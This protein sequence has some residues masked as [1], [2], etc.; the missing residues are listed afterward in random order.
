MHIFNIGLRQRG[1][2]FLQC[3]MISITRVH[4]MD[5]ISVAG[6]VAHPSDS[7]D[8]E[9][10]TGLDLAECTKRFTAQ[11]R[12][13]V[14]PIVSRC[15]AANAFTKTKVL[16]MMRAVL[17]GLETQAIY[18]T[19]SKSASA[20]GRGVVECLASTPSDDL[21]VSSSRTSVAPAVTRVRAGSVRLLQQRSTLTPL[22]ETLPVAPEIKSLP[23]VPD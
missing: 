17:S 2:G 8:L 10:A 23:P 19:P 11:P 15:S 5:E 4:I 3:P 1:I 14:P 6:H 16:P 22:N 7:V 20:G 9:Q 18:A 13:I 12:E 21:A